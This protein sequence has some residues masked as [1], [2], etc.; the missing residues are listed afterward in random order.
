MEWFNKFFEKWYLVL[1]GLLFWG[2]IFGACLFY[3]LG[4]SLFVSSLG[5]FLGLLFGI[6]AQRKGWG[7]IQ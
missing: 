6:L 4:A 5:Y 7:W 1:Y 2:S 3:V